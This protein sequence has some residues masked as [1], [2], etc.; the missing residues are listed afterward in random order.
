MSF[1]TNLTKD[2][3]CES[4]DSTKYRGMI[5]EILDE[6]DNWGIDPLEFISRVNLSFKNHMKVDGRTKKD[7][8][9]KEIDNV[10]EVST[11]WK[12]RRVGVSKSQD[13]IME[14]LVRISKKALILELKRRP[15][16][17]TVL[18]TNTPLFL[19]LSDRH[20]TYYETTNDQLALGWRHNDRSGGNQ[21]RGRAY[22]ANMN[23]AEAAKDS[24]VATGTFSINDHF[25]TGMFDS[26]ADFSFISTKFAPM[27]N[28]KPS[29]ANLGYVIEI[30]DCKKVEVDWIICGCKLELGSSLFT[31]DLI[32]LGHGSFD[33]IV[34]M[35][36]LSHNKAMIVCHE[37][38]VEIPLVDDEIL[39]V[40][41]ERVKDSTKALKNAKVDEPKINDISVLKELQEQGFH[42]T[43][44][45][46]WGAHCAI[47]GRKDGSIDKEG[48]ITRSDIMLSSAVIEP[49][50][51]RVTV[52]FLLIKPLPLPLPFFGNS[53]LVDK[54]SV[55]G[56]LQLASELRVDSWLIRVAK[57]DQNSW[58]IL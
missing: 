9:K 15:W 39:R 33:V 43:S 27:L 18:T 19:A 8:A 52:A 1:D 38:V 6:G 5:D 47:R 45:S 49:F 35:D 48:R 20:P 11:I 30:A 17:I 2:E 16:K 29:I 42:T 57:Q 26:G 21:V 22:N 56:I 34:G 55:N 24:S 23:M 7:L 25:T 44:H 51:L 53:M 58:L 41:G 36:W 10:G 37:K 32:P 31:I 12:S 4:V 3:E 54:A 14:Y 13:V 50:L 28:V 40:H 46:T